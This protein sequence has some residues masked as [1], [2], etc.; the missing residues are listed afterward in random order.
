MSTAV[1]TPASRS[2]RDLIGGRWLDASADTSS[3]PTN[4]PMS[5][6]DRGKRHTSMMAP[7]AITHDT[8]QRPARVRAGAP[9]A[10]FGW[11][12]HVKTF[13]TLELGAMTKP[14]GAISILMVRFTDLR[15][16]RT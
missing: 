14:T 13:L 3:R 1:A 16:K 4:R 12:A 6:T 5:G 10:A 15:G 11:S 2:G 9:P 7:A 8:Y